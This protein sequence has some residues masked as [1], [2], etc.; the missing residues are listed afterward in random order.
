MGSIKRFF[1]AHPEVILTS[2]AVF[3][4]AV[5]TISYFWGTSILLRSVNNALRVS[6]VSEKPPGF[7]IEGAKSLNLNLGH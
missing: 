6:S 1:K 7:N 3:L 2:S 5:I 4:L